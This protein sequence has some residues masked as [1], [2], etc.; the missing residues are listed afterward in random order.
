MN[1]KKP[2]RKFNPKNPTWECQIRTTDKNV[3]K[4]WENAGLK[5]KAILPDEGTPYY[6]V[7]LKRKTIKHDGSLA[8]CP[9]CVDRQLQPLN[10]DGVGNGS[11]ADVRIFFYDF[12]DKE[13]SAKGKAPVLMGIKVLKQ[14]VYVPSAREDEFEADEEETE[15]VMPPDYEED[16][17]PF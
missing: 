11:I 3:K 13:T 14:L 10:P 16:D 9:T 17:I 15:T 5:P 6:R 1:P 8:D 12:I 2:S 7:N 4:E